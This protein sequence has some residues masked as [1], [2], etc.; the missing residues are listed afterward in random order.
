MAQGRVVVYGGKGALGQAVI[1]HFKQSGYVSECVCEL[2]DMI[3]CCSGLWASICIRTRRQTRMWSWTRRR[4]GWSKRRTFW[5]GL[6][7]PWLQ[8]KWMAFS[9]WQVA[10][11]AAAPRRLSSSKTPIW[12][13]NNRYCCW[14]ESNWIHSTRFITCAQFII[15][16]CRFGA[17]RL[18]P[19]S[20]LCTSSLEAFCSWLGPHRSV[21]QTKARPLGLSLI[22]PLQALEGTPGMIG[23]GMA[24]AAVHQLTA[25]L[26]SKG[27]G[28]PE[29]STVILTLF[30]LIYTPSL[31]CRL[32]AF[33]QSPSTLPWIEN[34]CLRPILERKCF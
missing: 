26:A 7:R 9:V 1:E 28:L 6:P 21:A 24:K 25:S 18:R 11:R 33:C 31:L 13:G 30:P 10:G 19:E 5:A 12:C 8:T 22:S 17:A 15:L 29:G 27:S 20:H 32:S 34:G 23:Y 3:A 4:I 16:C 14:I 2:T